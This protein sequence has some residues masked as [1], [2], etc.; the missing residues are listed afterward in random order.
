[1]YRTCLLEGAMDALTDC[2]G[3]KLKYWTLV[4]ATAYYEVLL[5]G[6][7]WAMLRRRTLQGSAQNLRWRLLNM[8]LLTPAPLLE[9]WQGK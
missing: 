4:K 1:M 9:L 2:C 8:L 6:K 5:I 7:V 3:L